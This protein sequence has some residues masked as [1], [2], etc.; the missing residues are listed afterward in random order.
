M[1]DSGDM[2]TPIRSYL[3]KR[4]DNCRGRFYDCIHNV[5][6][7]SFVSSR[8]VNIESGNK[9]FGLSYER[10]AA[11]ALNK[12]FGRLVWTEGAIFIDFGCGKGL[13]LLSAA[14]HSFSKV[15]GVEYS[16]DL[17]AIAQ[18][19]VIRYRGP[20]RSRKNIS[21]V[22]G[23]AAR[24]SF[25]PTPLVCYFFN[26]FLPVVMEAVLENLVASW[27]ECP[28]DIRLVFHMRYSRDLL[29]SKFRILKF[30][31]IPYFHIYQV[32]PAK[33]EPKKEPGQNRVWETIDIN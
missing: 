13:A 14:K 11:R 20:L 23:D 29:L 32:V 25:P 10:T 9:D 33:G 28:R 15:I 1:G 24:F 27:K 26:P 7:F 18:R 17:V 22:H 16:S 2:P 8:T 4:L 19:N 12:L 5:D 3:I 31:S 30:E 21:I 6:T